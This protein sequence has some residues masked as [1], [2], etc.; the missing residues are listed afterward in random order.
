VCG[1]RFH[2]VLPREIGTDG[3]GRKPKWKRSGDLLVLF[4]VIFKDL[5][6][7]KDLIR[8]SC[9]LTFGVLEDYALLVLLYVTVCSAGVASF[10]P[11]TSFHLPKYELTRLD[12]RVPTQEVDSTNTLRG[13]L[14]EHISNEI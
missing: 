1:G 8:R 9:S 11:V 7:L 6:E 3:T 10:G 4:R 2:A 5:K 14:R 12:L 13:T